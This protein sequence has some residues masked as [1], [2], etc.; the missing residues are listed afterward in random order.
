MPILAAACLA[1]VLSSQPADALF[2]FWAVGEVYSSADGTVQFIELTALLGSQQSVAGQSIRSVN[3]TGTNTFAFPANLSG[4][5]ANKT[6]IIGTSNLVSIPGGVVPDFFIPNNFIQPAIGGAN[7]TVTYNGSGSSITYTN[8]PT[9]GDL[10]LTLSG[11]SVILATNS[12]KNYNGQSNTIVPVKFLSANV[13]NPN[14]VMSFRTAT[15]VNGG[16]GPN[17]AVEALSAIT[18]TNWVAISNV[19]GNGT[20]RTVGIPFSPFSNKFFRLRSP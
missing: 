6:C 2:H 8:L 12:P 16:T 9:D 20:T 18:S 7:A 11:G 5:S 13:V 1:F 3:S 14:F 19:T 10:S 17:Y 4:D 15:G